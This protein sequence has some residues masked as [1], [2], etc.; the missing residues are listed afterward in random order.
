[1]KN[2][3]VKQ[4]QEAVKRAA[5]AQRQRLGTRGGGGGGGAQRQ[6]ATA[7][8]AEEEEEGQAGDEEGQAAGS[9]YADELH[10]QFQQLLRGTLQPDLAAVQVGAAAR[11]MSAHYIHE[12][13][14]H[15]AETQPA[16]RA[17]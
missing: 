9:F 14:Q 16:L 15:V 7:A 8:A 11:C 13:A 6:A 2:A 12:L 17:I 4:T 3:L 10:Q 5:P 1:M